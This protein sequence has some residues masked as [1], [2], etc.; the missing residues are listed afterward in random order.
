MAVPKKKTAIS[1]SRTRHT[2]YVEKTQA[3]FTDEV[4][5]VKCKNCE[6]IKRSHTIC[7]SCGFYKGREVQVK[8]KAEVTTVQV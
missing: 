6:E 3:R 8:K 1:K 5:L 2:A 4:K 7:P